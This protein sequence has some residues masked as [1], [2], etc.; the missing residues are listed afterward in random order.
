MANIKSLADLNGEDGDDDNRKHNDYYAGGEKRWVGGVGG[1]G[2][3][4][5]PA[6]C[7]DVLRETQLI[8]PCALCLPLPCTQW[9]ADQGSPRG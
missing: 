8:T 6:A 7:M 5:S 9:A 3:A 4:G 2:A 1:D